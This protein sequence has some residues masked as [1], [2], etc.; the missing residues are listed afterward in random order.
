M[1]RQLKTHCLAVLKHLQS[2]ELDA[3]NYIFM[4]PVDLTL[5]PDYLEKCP[6]PMDFQTIGEKLEAGEYP[7]PAA[8]ADD[9]KLTF[10]NAIDYNGKVKER[11]R[12]VIALSKRDVNTELARSS[13]GQ[14]RET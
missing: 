8:F 3:D 2:A 1:Q 11:T 9:V 14:A 7:T 5:F 13:P 4:A 10:Q 6:K 12:R